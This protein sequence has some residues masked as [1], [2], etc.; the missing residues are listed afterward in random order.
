MPRRVY[1]CKVLATALVAALLIVGC[2]GAD[3]VAA[4]A[5][6]A[7]DCQAVLARTVLAAPNDCVE[8]QKRVD[9]VL[10]SDPACKAHYG[11]TTFDVCGKVKRGS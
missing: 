7:E 9:A 6:E 1:T 4:T 2:G 11:G 10:K 3:H 5:R 8:M